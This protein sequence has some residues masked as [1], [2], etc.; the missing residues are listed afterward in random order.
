MVWTPTARLGNVKMAWPAA[1]R[2]TAPLDTGTLSMTKL[3][4]PL[5][6][7]GIPVEG[8]T[9]LTVAVSVTGWPG[10]GLTGEAAMLTVVLPWLTWIVIGAPL[11]G[12]KLLSPL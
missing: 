3:T 4:V 12:L 10:N 11:A 6:G 9:G 5:G 8:A 1:L 7:I 2:V